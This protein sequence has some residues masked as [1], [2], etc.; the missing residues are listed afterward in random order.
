MAQDLLCYET[1][2]T[3]KRAYLDST[4]IQDARVLEVMNAADYIYRPRNYFEDFQDEIEP[5]MRKI[6][7][8]WMLE[9]NS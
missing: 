2:T 8:E 1:T 6:V 3:Q 5:H 7:S 9:V 4:L